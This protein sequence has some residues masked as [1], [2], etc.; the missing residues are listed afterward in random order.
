MAISDKN[1]TK[2]IPNVDCKSDHQADSEES[3]DDSMSLIIDLD[4]KPATIK[5]RVSVFDFDDKTNIGFN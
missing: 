4:N 5:G 3:A 2:L 1:P